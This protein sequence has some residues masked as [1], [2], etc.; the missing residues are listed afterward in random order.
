[1]RVILATFMG[2]V[3]LAVALVEAASN[4]D[5]DNWVQLSAARSFELADE[6]AGSVGIRPSGATGGADW[7]WGPCVPSLR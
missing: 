3:A 6:A 7:W 5:K 1:M 4:P 2:L